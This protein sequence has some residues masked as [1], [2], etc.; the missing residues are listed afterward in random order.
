MLNVNRNTTTSATHQTI[1]VE[2]SQKDSNKI[3]E[4]AK[5]AQ[6]QQP[7]DQT[8]KKQRRFS[9]QKEGFDDSCA[10]LLSCFCNCLE[11]CVEGTFNHPMRGYKPRRFHV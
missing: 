6:A 8:S 9:V 7:Q 4:A 5:K 11:I 3:S 10:Q 1:P 2:N